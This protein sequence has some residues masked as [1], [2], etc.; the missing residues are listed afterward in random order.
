MDRRL[1]YFRYA[2]L[3][4]AMWYPTNFRMPTS[5]DNDPSVTLLNFMPQYQETFHQKYSGTNY[6][7]FNYT[8][9]TSLHNTVYIF[10]FVGVKF[11]WILW[12][13]SHP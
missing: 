3:T 6:L 10:I 8:Y 11:L 5:F 12:S 9:V 7:V 4:V 1:D 2:L 13:L